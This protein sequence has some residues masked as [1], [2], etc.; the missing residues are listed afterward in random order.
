LSA[1]FYAVGYSGADFRYTLRQIYPVSLFG[2]IS[3][4]SGRH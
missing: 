2:M 3:S 4:K 1:I